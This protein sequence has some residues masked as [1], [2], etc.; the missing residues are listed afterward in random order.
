[1]IIVCIEERRLNWFGE[2][3]KDK[4]EMNGPLNIF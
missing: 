1:M 2:Q 4:W 3:G